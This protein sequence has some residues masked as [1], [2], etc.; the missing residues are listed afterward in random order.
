VEVVED[1]HQRL[2]VG[3]A[4]QKGRNRV[5]QA[6]PGLLRILTLWRHQLG[7]TGITEGGVLPVESSTTPTVHGCMPL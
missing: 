5:E 2:V 7:T 4:L 3:G 6:E 1:E